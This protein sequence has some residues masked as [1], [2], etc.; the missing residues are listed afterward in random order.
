MTQ[1]LLLLSAV[2]S[3]LVAI[4]HLYVV[5]KGPWAYRFFGAGEKLAKLAEQGSWAPAL[6]TFGISVIFFVFAAYYLA[7]AGLL[8]RL[9]LFK[10][11]LIGIAAIYSLRGAGIFPVLL[12]RKKFSTFELWSS[13]ISLAIG[14]VHCGAAWLTL[15]P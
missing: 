8:P 13:L 6:L 14:L 9:P 11:G 1:A 15:N 3:V 10:T 12:M 4:L 5:A 2:C 7:A